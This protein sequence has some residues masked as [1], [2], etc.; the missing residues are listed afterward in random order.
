MS[1]I[2][3][4]ICWCQIGNQKKRRQIKIGK[5]FSQKKIDNKIVKNWNKNIFVLRLV[6]LIIYKLVSNDKFRNLRENVF[7]LFKFCLEQKTR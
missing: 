5:N 2:E 1:N 4:L 6:Y 3:K 7:I